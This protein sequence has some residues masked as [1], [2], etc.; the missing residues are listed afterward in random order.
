[1]RI[2]HK[3]SFVLCLIFFYQTGANAQTMTPVSAGCQMQVSDTNKSRSYY[4]DVLAVPELGIVKYEVSAWNFNGT[5]EVVAR[6]DVNYP[7]STATVLVE[8]EEGSKTMTII[9]TYKYKDL[10]NV[11]HSENITIVLT[12]VRYPNNGTRASGA[13][14]YGVKSITDT[15]RDSGVNMTGIGDC[16][17]NKGFGKYHF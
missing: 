7:E 6:G 13:V 1:M 11:E 5:S 10:K 8:G 9:G 15:K 12:Q 17:D 16:F 4:L 3:I 2:L 14:Y